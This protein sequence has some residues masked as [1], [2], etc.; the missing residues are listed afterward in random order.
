MFQIRSTDKK[1][2]HKKPENIQKYKRTISLIINSEQ[3]TSST[4]SSNRIA[5]H[6][7]L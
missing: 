4:G 7:I 1:L 3:A 2:I 5:D 6:P